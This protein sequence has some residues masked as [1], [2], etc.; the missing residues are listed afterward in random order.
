VKSRSLRSLLSR[1]RTLV[2]QAREEREMVVLQFRR[3][4]IDQIDAEIAR[5]QASS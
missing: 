2:A 3:Y 5:R 1:R 4:Q